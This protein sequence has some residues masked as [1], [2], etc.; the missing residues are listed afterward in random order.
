MKHIKPAGDQL[1]EIYTFR[2]RRNLIKL[3][4]WAAVC[5]GVALAGCDLRK[6]D[7]SAETNSRKDS[8]MESTQATTMIENKIP[9]LDAAAAA[10]TE[11]ATFALG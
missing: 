8:N 10:E 4:C 6:V 2:N 11:T 1:T 9:P 7:A 3:L 5:L